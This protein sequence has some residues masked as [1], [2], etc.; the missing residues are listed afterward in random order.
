M[1]YFKFGKMILIAMVLFMCTAGNVK[2]AD[3]TPSPDDTA[4]SEVRVTNVHMISYDSTYI[5]FG[6]DKLDA[7]DG[8][9]IWLLD[10]AYNSY[11]LIDET[12]KN[13]YKLSELTQGTSKSFLVR[14]YRYDENKEKVIGN[15]SELFSAY[16][17]V[18][19][20][21]SSV[22]SPLLLIFRT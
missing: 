21:S 19:F 22:L 18:I 7:A 15:F 8:Y 20:S 16:S 11:N 10:K 17:A 2:A 5:E 3:E 4:F 6:W 13:E 1:R 9:E 14:P 12:E